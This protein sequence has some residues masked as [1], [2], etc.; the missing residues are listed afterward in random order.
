ML[1]GYDLLYYQRD[2]LICSKIY[3]FRNYRYG[4]IYSSDWIKLLFKFLFKAISFIIE[5]AI[6]KSTW[7]IS[8]ANSSRLD[9]DGRLLLQAYEGQRPWIEEWNSRN[10]PNPPDGRFENYS[11][12]SFF[13]Q[14]F[15]LSK[16]LHHGGRPVRTVI[17]DF[18][19]RPRILRP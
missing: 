9:I 7:L 11:P 4:L 16:V 8:M 17:T 1:L 6:N 15:T 12:T 10:V 3:K 13:Q 19:S 14:Q 18:E 5:T 2:F